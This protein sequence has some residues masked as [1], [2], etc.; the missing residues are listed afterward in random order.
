MESQAVP[1]TGEFAKLSE[2]AELYAAGR[3]NDAIEQWKS[4]SSDFRIRLMKFAKFLRDN[5]HEIASAPS[6]AFTSRF[7]DWEFDK[8]KLENVKTLVTNLVRLQLGGH[9]GK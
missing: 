1:A 5:P 3:F 2:I 8:K 4:F 6:A 9:N 7:G